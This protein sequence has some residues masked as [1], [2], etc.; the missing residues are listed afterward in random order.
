MLL[1]LFL[2]F[3][4]FVSGLGLPGLMGMYAESDVH[5]L[6]TVTTLHVYIDWS[7]EC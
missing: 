6:V 1:Q 2:L 7:P 5:V 4:Y 3:I